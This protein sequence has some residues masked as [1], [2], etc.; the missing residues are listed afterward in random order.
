MEKSL[1][2]LSA[3]KMAMKMVQQTEMS[4]VQLTENDLEQPTVM[5]KAMSLVCSSDVRMEMQMA[6]KMASG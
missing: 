5:L 4:L 2:C 3:L 1:V 6:L